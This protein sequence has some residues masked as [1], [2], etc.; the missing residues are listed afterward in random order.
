MKERPPEKSL[1]CHVTAPQRPFRVERKQLAPAPCQVVGPPI[2][3]WY[4]DAWFR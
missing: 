2:A 1:A 3:P 4:T